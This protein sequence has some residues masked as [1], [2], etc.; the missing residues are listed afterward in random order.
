MS[1]RTGEQ[2]KGILTTLVRFHMWN[3][4]YVVTWKDFS[5]IGGESNHYLLETKESLFI[6]SLNAKVTVI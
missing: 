3:C 5:I 4:C 6:N 1:P 2:V